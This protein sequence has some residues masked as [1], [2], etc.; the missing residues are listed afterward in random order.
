M[1]KTIALSAVLLLS[2]CSTLEFLG[3]QETDASEPLTIEITRDSTNYE[4]TEIELE[5]M[6]IRQEGY[7][8]KAY[9][10]N[11]DISVGH[12]RNLTSNG[13]TPEEARYLLR[14][15]IKRVQEQLSQRFPIYLQLD[16]VRRAVLVSMGYNMGI[17]RLSKFELMWKN[18][19]RGDYTRAGLEIYL[20]R[21]CDQVGYRCGELANMME[22][23]YTD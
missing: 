21:Y 1:Q 10:D 14:N 22:K 3:I 4:V 19:E 16:S 13:I 9:Y 15:D 17:D 20:S 6:I 18:L 2:G 5:N 7:S 12:G 11:G 23:G 8:K